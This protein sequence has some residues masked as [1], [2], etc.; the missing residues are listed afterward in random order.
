MSPQPSGAQNF[1]S[2]HI[3]DPYCELPFYDSSIPMGVICYV[4]YFNCV[5]LVTNEFENLVC[6]LTIHTLCLFSSRR[7][8]FFLLLYSLL[9]VSRLAMS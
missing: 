7:P 8:V 3:I 2:P 6:H 1:P 5:R 4:H 9:L